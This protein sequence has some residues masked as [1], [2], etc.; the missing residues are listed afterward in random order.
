LQFRILDNKEICDS[1]ESSYIRM[2]KSMMLRYDENVTM[3]E[4]TM[5]VHI[6][7]IGKLLCTATWKIETKVGEWH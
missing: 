4:E 3:M 7:L 5:N 6:I 2:V 1:Y